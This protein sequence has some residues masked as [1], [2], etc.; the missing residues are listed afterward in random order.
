MLF[1]AWMLAI[2][3]RGLP[4]GQ[5]RPELSRAAP[6]R[7]GQHRYLA[8]GFGGAAMAAL[9][10]PLVNF[11]VIPAAVAGATILWVERLD[12]RPPAGRRTGGGPIRDVFEA[13]G[14]RQGARFSGFIAPATPFWY[15]PASG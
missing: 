6:H 10:I 12:R 8:L 3:Y 15:I 11:L 1:G 13:D 7:L 2:S 14:T 5:P 4:H 9:A